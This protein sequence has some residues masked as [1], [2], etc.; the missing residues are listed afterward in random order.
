MKAFKN[1]YLAL[2]HAL[3]LL[4]SGHFLIFFIPG[5]VIASFYL[6][7]IIIVGSV[8][9]LVGFISYI[10]WIGSY[11]GLA[12]DSIF[13]GVNSVSIYL[14]QFTIITLLSPFHTILSERVETHKNGKTYKSNF[15][16]FFNDLLR[17]LGIAILGAIIYLSLFLLWS[18][19]AWIFNL[20]FL[21]PFIS[22]IL[23]AFFTGFNS[24]DYSL[25][26][27]GIKVKDSWVFAFQ[28]PLQMILTGLIFTIIL[29]IP[30]IGVVIAP[31]LLTMVGTINYLKLTQNQSI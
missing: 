25:E 28:N 3:T 11:M 21:S 5:L 31:V 14:Y 18:F 7:Y 12:V 30:V 16:K 13:N 4:L 26:R 6:I 24:Y 20:N 10:P 2:K 29:Y 19:L 17:T 8:G 27:H 9:S 15:S 1:H 22:A 23:I